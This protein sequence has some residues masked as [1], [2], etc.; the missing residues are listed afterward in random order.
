MCIR[1]VDEF[2]KPHLAASFY[3]VPA[4]F[5]FAGAL[6]VIVNNLPC[7]HGD[8]L[9]SCHGDNLPSCHSD[10]LPC[11]QQC[12][13][14]GLAT[15]WSLDGGMACLLSGLANH[16]TSSMQPYL[17]LGCTKILGLTVWSTLFCQALGRQTLSD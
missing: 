5:E 15:L 17:R 8:N 13:D 3:E 14:G 9:P 11:G 12:R 2:W 16:C 7:C 4:N 10:N 6:I 1:V